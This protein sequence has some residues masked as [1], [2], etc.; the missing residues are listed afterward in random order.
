VPHLHNDGAVHLHEDTRGI[1]VIPDISFDKIGAWAAAI[2]A[3][4]PDPDSLQTALLRFKVAERSATPSIGASV[5]AS[6]IRTAA[7]QEDLASLCSRVPPDDM[8]Q[9]SVDQ[10]L[11]MGRPFVVVF[12]TPAFCQSRLCGPVTDLVFSLE[13][14]YRSQVDFIHIE[15]Y[16]LD[17]Q[18]KEGRLELIPAMN[19]WGLPSEP[20]VFV[21]DAHGQLAAKF[22][23]P[24]GLDELDQ[25][26]SQ[27]SQ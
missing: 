23:G 24:F 15:P 22:E 17:L 1:Y 16:D 11:A 20:W 9:V 10:A 6:S 14:Q 21:V 19:E 18:R 5:P 26:I 7:S 13:D 25:A 4:L 27:V 8:H 12:A 3:T 2:Q